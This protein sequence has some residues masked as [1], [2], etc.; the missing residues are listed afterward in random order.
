MHTY[1]LESI[2]LCKSREAASD[3]MMN[4][5]LITRLFLRKGCDI[6]EA[7][8]DLV[9]RRMLNRGRPKF[10]GSLEFEKPLWQNESQY[11]KLW[12]SVPRDQNISDE[13]AYFPSMNS[14]NLQAAISSFLSCEN[15]I[16]VTDPTNMTETVFMLCALGADVSATDFYL[17]IHSIQPLH[18]IALI[19]YSPDMAFYI[20]TLFK[21][22]LDFG[23]NPCARTKSGWTVLDIALDKGW[24]VQWLEALRECN[25]LQ[26]IVE[27]FVAE[28][29]GRE[30]GPLHTTIRTGVD[31]TDL[32]KPSAQGLSRRIASRGDRLD[33]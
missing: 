25:Q 9:L 1:A 3:M 4:K 30:E 32:S 28:V 31:I 17:S 7:Y 2:E 29:F 6:N 23:A 18:L 19:P 33:D 8:K 11:V 16:Y 21:I 5:C 26:V 15:E 13:Y 20:K 22:L 12:L 24:D 27:Q 14:T 10:Y